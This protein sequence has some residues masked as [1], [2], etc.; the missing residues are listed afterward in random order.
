MKYENLYNNWLENA[1]LDPD[2]I[3]ELKQVKGHE[4]EISDRFYCSLEFG[5]A[6][7]RGVIGA[8]TNRMNVYTVGITTQ[9][10]SEYVNSVKKGGSAAVSYDS[11]IKSNLF[12]KMTASVFAANGIKVYMYD[13]LMPTPM[14]S[15]AVRHFKCDVG[16]MITASHNPAKY[17]GYKVYGND[18]CQLGVKESDF[19]S[20]IIGKMDIF[21]DIKIADFDKALAD[22]MIEY[23]KDDAIEAYLDCVEAQS[24]CPGVSEGS[25]FSI[26]YSP[27]HGTGNKPVRKILDRI[28]IKNVTVVKEQELPDGNFPTVPFPNPEFRQAFDLAV[29]LAKSKPADL[30]LATDPDCDRVGIAVPDGED[31]RLFTGNQVGAMLL[32]YILS[33]K[34]ELGSLEKN[35][36]AVKTIVTTD[37]CVPIAKKY[38]CQMIDVLTGF[39]YIGEQIAILEAKG[40]EARYQLGF[41]ESYGYLK[42]S[43][44][45]DKDAVVASMLIAEMACYYKGKGKSLIDVYEG[46]EKEFGFFHNSQSSFYFEGQDGMAKMADMMNSLSA[47]PPKTVAGLTVTEVGDYRTST[48]T[49]T[50]TGEKSKIELPKASVLYFGLGGGNSVIVRPSGTEPKIKIYV[51]ATADSKEKADSLAEGFENEFK[52]IM[53]I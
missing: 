48:L 37:M 33:V 12:A 52:V 8:G 41:E 10:I 19:I 1:T 31:Y 35:P 14:L 18:G 28:G 30:L 17:N 32:N 7:L 42:G 6:G 15:F 38:G 47:D 5:T 24:V 22:G 44:V 27:L 40:E 50:L 13:E 25:D 46:L 36:I 3:D 34:T 16:V 26:I 45:R 49:N 23:I 43:Y 53:G 39:K 2:L 11:R 51:T 21:K 20:D 4:D 9:G 29:E